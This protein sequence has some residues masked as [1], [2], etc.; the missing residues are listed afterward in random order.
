MAILSRAVFEYVLQFGLLM[1]T[2]TEDLCSL[3]IPLDVVGA[4]LRTLDLAMRRHRGSVG[5]PPGAQL[6]EV[7][8]HNPEHSAPDLSRRP[9]LREYPQDQQLILA[10]PVLNL[11]SVDPEV[12]PKQREPGRPDVRPWQ[13]PKLL[14]DPFIENLQRS[15]LIP[16]GTKETPQVFERV[17]FYVYPCTLSVSEK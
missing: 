4:I 8:D 1:G 2:R 15:P 9:S 3:T 17:S 13:I 5:G 7:L 6:V 12:L 11:I 16:Y 14:A 10:C